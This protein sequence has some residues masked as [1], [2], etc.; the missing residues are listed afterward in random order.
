MALHVARRRWGRGFV[1]VLTISALV[2]AGTAGYTVRPG[3]TLSGIAARHG[4]SVSALASVNTIADPNLIRSGQ[5][6]RIPGS[7]GGSGSARSLHVVKPGETVI[8]ISIRYGVPVRRIVNANRLANEHLV[9][10]GQRLR[11]P[12]GSG[13]L[14]SGAAPSASRGEVERLLE[15]TARRYGFTPAFIKAI[16]WQESGWNQS[17]RSSAGAVGVMQVLPSTGR[18]VSTYLVRRPLD[19]R[20]TS[21]NITAGVAFIS[22]LWRLTG[23]NVHRVLAGYYQ[24]LASVKHNGM[25]PSTKRY[26]ANVLAL[27]DRF[28]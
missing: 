13:A 1:G 4:L 24:G 3:D 10:A 17:A 15:Q 11:I 7:A 25:Y 28:L 2:F 20:K 18:W 6:L 23:G 19:L 16:A 27:R 21:D 14:V 22:Y 5:R 9:F 26:I 12:S 8:G